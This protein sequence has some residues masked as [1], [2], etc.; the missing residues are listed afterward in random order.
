MANTTSLPSNADAHS[1]C[2]NILI[3]N[4][5]LGNIF[6]TNSPTY[7]E[8]FEFDS[9]SIP[10]GATID[11]IQVIVEIEA[12]TYTTKPQF[13]VYNGAWSSLVDISSAPN[14]RPTT[15]ITTPTAEDELWGMT[16]NA[17]TAAAIQVRMAWTTSGGDAVYLDYVKVR[18]TYTETAVVIHP[19]MQIKSGT[20]NLKSGNL[21]IK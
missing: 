11:G 10:A 5:V 8:L 19:R 1:N 20:L 17:T 13:Q 4:D 15:V 3:D 16:W 6:Q 21:I 12:N 2:N 9:L 7:C 18:I 14:K